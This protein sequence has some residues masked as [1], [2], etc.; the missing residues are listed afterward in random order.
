MKQLLGEEK[1]TST[2]RERDMEK[3][4]SEVADRLNKCPVCRHPHRIAHLS[5]IPEDTKLSQ[6]VCH[7]KFDG[8][9]GSYLDSKTDMVVDVFSYTISYHTYVV[10]IIDKAKMEDEIPDDLEE[11]YLE[12][13]DEDDLTDS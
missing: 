7:L 1:K 4:L 2:R 13:Q 5:R 6:F 10:D 8:Y 11:E 3:I 12:F 9:I